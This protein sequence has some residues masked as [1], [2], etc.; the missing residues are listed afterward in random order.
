MQI[1]VEPI[2]KMHPS[3]ESWPALGHPVARDR[4]ALAVGRSDSTFSDHGMG[5]DNFGRNGHC[6]PIRWSS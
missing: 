6:A 4:L 3:G 1:A 2:P 5:R